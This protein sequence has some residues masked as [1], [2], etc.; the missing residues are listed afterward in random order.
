MMFS[1]LLAVAAATAPIPHMRTDCWSNYY[2]TP[3]KGLAAG[4][5]SV[6]VADLTVNTRGYVDG[7]TGRVFTCN[8]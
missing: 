8:P 1:V 4:E 3:K 7:C 6:V 5:L 2:D